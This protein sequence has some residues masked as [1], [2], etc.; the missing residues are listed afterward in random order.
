MDPG[1][2]VTSDKTRLITY[3]AMLIV[4]PLPEKSE[5]NFSGFEVGTASR[6]RSTYRHA[7]DEP[8]DVGGRVGVVDEALHLE[9]LP[10]TVARFESHQ[11]RSIARFN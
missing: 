6:G 11:H 3:K 9:N 4:D 2:T 5:N 1:K 8:G 10:D 7:V